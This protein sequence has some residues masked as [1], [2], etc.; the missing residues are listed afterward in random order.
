MPDWN[1]AEMIGIKPRPLACSL[2]KQLITD[3]N[4][5]S[6]RFR[7]GYRDMRDKPLMFQ[8]C[9]SPYV[10]IPHSVESFIPSALP[11]DIVASTVTTCCS[12]LAAS[13]QLHDKV[14]FAIVPTCFTPSLAEGHGS[15]MAA[16][17]GLN[18]AQRALYLTEL[19]HVTEHIACADGP[20]FGDL[21][22]LPRLEQRLRECAHMSNCGDSL[23]TFR[24]SLAGAKLVAEVFAGVAR[25]AFIATA[26]LKSLEELE[27]VRAGFADRLIGSAN[28]IGRRLSDDFRLLPKEGFL[29]RHGHVRPGTYDIRVPRYDEAPGIYF[30]WTT[31]VQRAANVDASQLIDRA[32][33]SAIQKSFDR[34]D[35]LVAA[36]HFAEF[37]LT[38]VTARENV[39]YLYGGF[40]SE[41]LKA[42]AAWGE[43][44][45][46]DRDALSFVS[47][48]DL[49][50]SAEQLAERLPQ[51]IEEGR[52]RWALMH[53]VRAPVI[54]CRPDD[55][56]AHEVLICHPSFVT[57]CSATAAVRRVGA[58]HRPDGDLADCIVLIESADPGF[59]WI[60]T[61][62]IAG[63]IT[64]YGGENSHM[65]I[66]A[67]EFSTPAAIGVGEA[68]F[69]TLSMARRVALDCA[70]RRIQVI[71]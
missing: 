6:A 16:F 51:S 56:F 35:L 4:W 68:T 32:S 67:R 31:P 38:A 57:R 17:V 71:A 55:L 5:A 22:L 61:R 8:F 50:G 9:G 11:D 7:Y 36:P 69:R 58:G 52:I 46:I 63:F 19:K 33:L 62:R 45:G 27:V 34:C 12:Q 39:K 21:T 30:D 65:S 1:P 3:V 25:A 43:E 18:Q 20:F 15:C 59:D 28:T 23:Q 60:F 24:R 64:A 41:A 54:I 42:F 10:C 2:Y 26:I 14:E 29:A 49:K 44:R 70:A 53:D 47:L 48:A 13:P 40:L 66:R 37:A